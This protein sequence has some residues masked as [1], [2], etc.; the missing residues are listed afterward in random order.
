MGEVGPS[1]PAHLGLVV[2][3]QRVVGLCCHFSETHATKARQGC[4][5]QGVLA[6]TA[7]KGLFL[8]WWIGRKA[9]SQ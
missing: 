5:S 9:Q 2:R 1:F 8:P 6:L 7:L 3:G 4:T